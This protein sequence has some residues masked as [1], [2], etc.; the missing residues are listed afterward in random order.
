M[1]GKAAVRKHHGDIIDRK[2]AACRVCHVTLEYSAN[3]A[4][5][6]D[7]T[8][9]KHGHLTA[10][11]TTPSDNIAIVVDSIAIVKSPAIVTSNQRIYV[12][13]S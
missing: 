2:R 3:T 4:N 9:R 8:R 10:P 13:S 12:I 5:M 1:N 7:H 6:I 11:T